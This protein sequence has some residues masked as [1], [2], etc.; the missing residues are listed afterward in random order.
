MKKAIAI[1]VLGLLWCNIGFAEM[2]LIEEKRRLHG[3][4]INW[5]IMNVCIDGYKFVIVAQQ[6]PIHGSTPSMV[7]A[8]EERDGKSLPAKC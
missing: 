3:S 1:I 5:N 2:R 8:Y 7:Q 4:D 6:F